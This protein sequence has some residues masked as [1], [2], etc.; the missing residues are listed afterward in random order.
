MARPDVPSMSMRMR[1]V[2]AGAASLKRTGLFDTLGRTGR[3]RN[4][5]WAL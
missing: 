3:I 5:P 1:I 2:H 4:E